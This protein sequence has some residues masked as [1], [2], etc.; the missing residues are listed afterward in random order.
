M[1]DP[2]VGRSVD[3]TLRLV[4]A[5]QVRAMPQVDSASRVAVHGRARRGL[6][7]GLAAWPGHGAARRGTYAAH[8][9]Q[10][11]PNPSDKLAYFKKAAS[12]K[13]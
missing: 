12:K 1:N 5:Y 9:A 3:E 4:K 10:I 7:R 6:P 8:V 13:N 2:P 11:V